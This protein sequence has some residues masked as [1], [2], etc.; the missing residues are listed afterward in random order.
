MPEGGRGAYAHP[1]SV[2]PPIITIRDDDPEDTLVDDEEA[3]LLPTD[4]T[5]TPRRRRK[6]SFRGL[7]R[8]FG[9]CS[10]QLIKRTGEALKPIFTRSTLK[11]TIAYLIATLATILDHPHKELGGV[12]YL[13]AVAILFFHPSRTVGAMV[14]A[15]LCCVVGLTVGFIVAQGTLVLVEYYD[16][17]KGNIMEAQVIALATLCIETF[18]LAHIRA[19][20][21]NTRPAIATGCTLTHLLSFMCFTQMS[22]PKALPLSLCCCIFWPVTAAST[23]RNDV[24]QTLL[25][26]RS[27]F[28]SLSNTLSLNGDLPEHTPIQSTLSPA[29]EA[30]PYAESIASHHDELQKLVKDHQATLLH[31]ETARYEVIFEPTTS[32]F[33]HRGDHDRIFQSVER[34]T[35]HLG[36][37]KSSIFQIDDRLASDPSNTALSDFMD[38]MAPSL[39]RLITTTKQALALLRHVFDSHNPAGASTSAAYIVSVTG[40]LVESLAVAV[41]EF[42]EEM[43]GVLV[44]IYEKVEEDL[45]LVFFF[46]YAMV[47]VS[48]E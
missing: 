5:S 17:V 20:W 34:L 10:H 1:A 12:S 43:K 26:L 41:S 33:T 9:N 15:L 31:M 3:L 37:L 24:S 45:F 47:E 36:G 40:V 48:K 25:H 13:V 42:E 32:M 29:N 11:A 7:S 19:K 28:N 6:L 4:N 46:C 18:I 14:E 35:Q 39:R 27:F 8:K 21:G 22:N 44:G 23:L 38:K 2:A 16:D 30:L